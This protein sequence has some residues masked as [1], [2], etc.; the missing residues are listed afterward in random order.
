MRAQQERVERLNYFNDTVF[1]TPMYW[2]FCNQTS[3]FINRSG[4][5]FDDILFI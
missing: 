4:A 5:S 3:L 1:W 2:S